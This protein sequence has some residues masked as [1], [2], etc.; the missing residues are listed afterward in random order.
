L[1]KT[2]VKCFIVLCL[3]RIYGGFITINEQLQFTSLETL[4]WKKLVNGS[5]KKRMVFFSYHVWNN[6]VK[7]PLHLCALLSIEKRM[8]LLKQSIFIPIPRKYSDLLEDNHHFSIVY[9]ARRVQ[10]VV[11]QLPLYTNDALAVDGKP[12]AIK[13][14]WVT[15]KRQIQSQSTNFRL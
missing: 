11:K 12:Q 3:W 8:N 5:V 13:P 7:I 1:G 2:T 15:L 10:I 9:D 14:D 4:A 6:G